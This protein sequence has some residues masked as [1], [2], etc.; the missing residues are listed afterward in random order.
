MEYFFYSTI[1]SSYFFLLTASVFGILK[2]KALR[3]Y[4]Y[5]YF[6]YLAYTFIIEASVNITIEFFE[7]KATPFI[8]PFYIGGIFSIL[9]FLFIRKLNLPRIWSLSVP[10]IGI[11]YLFVHWFFDGMNH[12]HVKVISNII[13]FGFAGLCLLQ[14]LR[15]TKTD[16][17]FLWVDALIFLYYSVSA[18]IFILHNQLGNMS[19]Q[20]AYL[21]WG[22]N[23]I[24][25]CILYSSFI[26]T[27]S[28]L[29]K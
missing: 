21:I 26:Y 4:E 11:L 5:W 29:K 22:I 8:Y 10:A 1:Y 24:L 15:K 18:F 14:E 28:T 9:T 2:Y 23:N 27:F 17:R 19:I 3:S 12:D 20:H 13:I 16:N 7:A 6:Y 25:T